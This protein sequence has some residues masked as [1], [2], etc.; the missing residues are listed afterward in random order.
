M[1]IVEL[2]EF[3]SERG[4]GVRSYLDKLVVAA[5]RSGHEITLVAPGP[6]NVDEPLPGGGRLVRYAAPPMP[7]DNTYHAPL[8]VRRMRAIVREAKPDILQTSTPF[9][10][11]WVAM[12]CKE[13]PV[14]ALVYHSDPI[15][16]YLE[17]LA[18]RLPFGGGALLAPAWSYM[19]KITSGFDVT[20]VAGRWLQEELT[21]HGCPRAKTV[22][23]GIIAK[24]F[25]RHLRDLELRRQLLGSLA[26]DPKARLFLIAGRLA[27][28]KR[29]RRVIEALLE[30]AK[31]RPVGL[32]LLGDG[33]EREPLVEL[34]NKL[35]AFTAKPFTRDREEYARVL[36]S[37]DAVL[38]GSVSETF[39]FVLAESMASG[40]PMIVPRARGAA[41]LADG[42]FAELYE[43]E[44]DPADIADAIRR[45]LARPRDEMSA[46]AQLAAKRFPTMDDHFESLFALYAD[47]RA[48]AAPH[49]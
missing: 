21:R 12:S 14:R 33:P 34:G 3:Y 22:E 41:A 1:K 6:K 20:V 23:F 46:A 24:D 38:H 31:D 43:R 26:D 29:Q 4:G 18:T 19:R 7:Y 47:L 2:A 40:T 39:G 30:I 5:E 8:A 15:G 44:G 35:P 49:P 11:A 42:S 28:D 36:A 37:V 32:V 27:V 9:V 16:S 45:L 17:P 13:V 48:K 10:P 25:G